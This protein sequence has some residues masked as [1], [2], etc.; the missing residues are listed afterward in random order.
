MSSTNQKLIAVIGATGQQGGGVVEALRAAGQF[1]VRALTR[2][3]EKHP[4]LADEVVAA[5]LNRPETL[6][7]ALQGAYGLFLVTNFAEQG[8]D[9]FKQ[10]SAIIQ[11]AKVAG[12]QH[13]IWST[14]P[15]VEDLSA[16]KNR[17]PHFTNKAKIDDVVRQ[18]NFAHHTFVVASFYYQ[19]LVGA[20]APRKQEDG[21]LT[22]TLPIDPTVRGI[23][24]GDPTELG[25]IVAG[26]FSHPEEAGNGQYLPLVGDLVSFNDIISTL[27]QQGHKV[28]VNQVPAEVFAGFFPG[29]EEF[30]AMF[31]HFEEDTYLGAPM[32]EEIALANKLAG[33]TPTSFETWAREHFKS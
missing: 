33:R 8:A 21:T 2:N 27:S 13:L 22:W 30:A 26:A 14:L 29:A 18:A 11:A 24:I 25:A 3:P 23:H 1:K 15:N 32:K 12:V 28:A 20:L 4:D 19:N 5:D 6:A 7:A 16:G 17:V 9:E 10:A 31:K